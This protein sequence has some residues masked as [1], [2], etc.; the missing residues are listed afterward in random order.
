MMKTLRARVKAGWYIWLFPLLA[1]AITGYLFYNYYKEQGPKIYI[2]F[3]DASS[4]QPDKTEVRFRGVAI[5]KVSDVTISGDQR[6][7][8]VEVRLRKDARDFAIDGTKFSLVRPKVNFQGV[9]GLDTLF[10]GTYIAVFPGKGGDPQDHFKAQ[11]SAPVNVLDDTSA[12]VIEA[13]DAESVLSGD[14]VTFRGM[15]IGSVSKI[16]FAKGAQKVSL[17]INIDNKFAHLIRTNTV[18]WRKVGI[19]AKLGLFGSDIKVNSM[20]SILNGGV[21][22]AT[23]TQAGPR[24]K[25]FQKFVLAP[26]APKDFQKWKPDLF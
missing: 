22:I 24:A 23:P 11:S 25:A 10:E 21:Q 5:G 8:I 13:D 1:L 7:A 12:F 16:G 3:D 14:S 20:E 18:F 9:S 19:Q 17:Q 2:S 6:D 4:I 15:K 26:A